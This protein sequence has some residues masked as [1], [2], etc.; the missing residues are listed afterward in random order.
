MSLTT[1]GGEHIC[2]ICL[3]ALMPTDDAPSVLARRTTV[4]LSLRSYM[5]AGET[6]QGIAYLSASSL[7]AR[8]DLGVASHLTLTVK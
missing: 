6:Q 2:D 3:L 4:R 1:Y 7:Y 5:R 8:P